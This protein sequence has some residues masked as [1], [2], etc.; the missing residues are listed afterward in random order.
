MN[1]HASAL[2][3]LAKGHKKTITAQ[4][5]ARRRAHMLRVR[6]LRW[7]VKGLDIAKLLAGEAK[8]WRKRTASRSAS[9]V[10]PAA[11]RPSA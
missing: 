2:G 4:E 10:A 6:Q 3:R 8:S 7:P 1:A 5:R 11:N 9:P